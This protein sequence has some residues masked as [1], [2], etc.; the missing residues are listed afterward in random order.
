[1]IKTIAG[2]YARKRTRWPGQFDTEIYE[3]DFELFKKL[4]CHYHHVER[5]DV[6]DNIRGINFIIVNDMGLKVPNIKVRTA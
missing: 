1:M 5:K 3:A 4:K 2:D 6:L